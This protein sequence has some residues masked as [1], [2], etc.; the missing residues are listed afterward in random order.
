MLCG[1]LITMYSLEKYNK[2]KKDNYT[3][4]TTEMRDAKSLCIVAIIM[5]FIEFCLL[6]YA[7]STAVS[8]PVGSSLERFVH[9]F[10]AIFF[11]IPYI[12]VTIIAKFVVT[13]STPRVAFQ[14]RKLR[15][16]VPG[17]RY[18]YTPQRLTVVR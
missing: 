2:L 15:S 7:L 11:T 13:T 6:F 14:D 18:F 16:P 12:L 8:W 10:F 17:G 9:V 3:A 1:S 5:F 4:D